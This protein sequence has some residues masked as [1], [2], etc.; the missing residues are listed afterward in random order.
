MANFPKR[1]LRR[2]AVERRT[3]YKKTE[4][5]DLIKEDRFPK[6]VPLGRRAVG[7]LEHEIDQW[8]D[9]RI[10]ARDDK[11]GRAAT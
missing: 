2:P 9:E 10:R 8:I 6:P 4:L 7:W 5:Y 11:L 1:I 3:G